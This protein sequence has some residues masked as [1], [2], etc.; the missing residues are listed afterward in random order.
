M[1]AQYASEADLRQSRRK[2]TC[3][4][5]AIQVGSC[6]PDIECLVWDVSESG[7]KIELLS[8]EAVPDEF[9]LFIDERDVRRSCSV[10][11]RKKR[12]IGI[13]FVA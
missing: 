7:A 8:T 5:G 10:V 12:K 6:S 1:A 3:K 4:L 2:S 13:A 11:W 9:E